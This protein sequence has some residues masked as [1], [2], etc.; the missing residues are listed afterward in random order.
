MLNR[1]RG[2]YYKQGKDFG[3]AVN[4]KLEDVHAL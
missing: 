3:W 2:L 1:A 4:K